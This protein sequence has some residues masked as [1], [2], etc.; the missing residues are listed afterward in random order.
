MFWTDPAA[1]D[2]EA[3][4][5]YAQVGDAATNDAFLAAIEADQV[6]AHTEVAPGVE[7][8]FLANLTEDTYNL[9]I[10]G[11]DDD[12]NHSDAAQHAAWVGVPLDVTPPDAPV[13]GGLD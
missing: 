9:A 12:G 7:E 8:Y 4:E 3:I 5:I 6:A 1:T 10:A 11:R 2:L 13:P